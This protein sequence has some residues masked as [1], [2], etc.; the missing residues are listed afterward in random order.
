MT[1]Y[2]H[3][4]YKNYTVS[5]NETIYNSRGDEV[6]GTLVNGYLKI[7][8]REK[9]K[10]PVRYPVHEFVWGAYNDEENNDIY[11]IIHIDGNKLNNKI[12][13]SKTSFKLII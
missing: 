5:N 3:P 4:V 6:K 10:N 1:R 11:K 9:R 2:I 12:K 8:V 13:K 7:Y